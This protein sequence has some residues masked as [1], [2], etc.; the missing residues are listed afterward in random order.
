MSTPEDIKKLVLARLDVFPKDKK[1]SV[2]SIGE[3]TREELIEHIK[4][5][6]DIGKKFVSIEME[7]LRPLKS[8]LLA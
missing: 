6:D 5:D 7:F 3:F 4:K 1:I 2:G 8:G